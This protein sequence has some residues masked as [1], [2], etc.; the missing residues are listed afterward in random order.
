MVA[1][2]NLRKPVKLTAKGI[3]MTTFRLLILSLMLLG[4]SIH[5]K[6][7]IG[8][9]KPWRTLKSEHLVVMTLPQGN[10]VIELAPKFAP[11][12]VKQFS[13]LVQNKHYDGN[14]FYRVID[15]FVAQVGPEDGS[16]EDNNVTPLKLEGE[17]RH[18]KRDY[19]LVQKNDLFAEETGFING[20]AVGVSRSEKKQWLAHCPGVVAM[21]RGNDKDSATSH[22]YITNGQAPRY[23]DRLMTVFGRVVYG[24]EHV[25]AIQRTTVM[26]GQDEIPES[27]FT[28]ITKMQMM[29]DLPKEQQM[30]IAVENTHSK[31]FSTRLKKRKERKHP[32]FFKAP[33]QVLDICQVAVKS[34][35][36]K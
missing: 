30:K 1:N 32:F 31:A 19:T 12:H 20:F 6:S 34:K 22:F 24:M 14:Q 9:G 11:N 27:K 16:Q 28:S 3:C 29:N 13:T 15:G 5:A 18:Y 26:E 35:L 10:V 17:W 33:P 7:G 2:H 23:L 25:Q 4:I 21:A 36:L 8:D